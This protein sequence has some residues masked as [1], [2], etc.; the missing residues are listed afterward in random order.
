MTNGTVCLKAIGVSKK[1]G[2]TPALSNIDFSLDNGEIHTVLGAK[3]AGKS[4]LMQVLAGGVSIDAGYV[5]VNG[6]RPRSH[7]PSFARSNGMQSL[8]ESQYLMQDLTVAENIF[9]G[10]YVANRAGFLNYK[11]LK[12][13]AEEIFDLLNVPINPDTLPI[14]LTEFERQVVQMARVYANKAKIVLADNIASLFSNGQKQQIL[15]IMKEMAQ[16]GIGV[17]YFTHMVEDALKISSRITV[18][19]DGERIC[20]KQRKAFDAKNLIHE[21]VGFDETT[22]KC[23]DIAKD[24]ED[25][26]IFYSLSKAAEANENLVD[27]LKNATDYINGHLEESITPQMVADAV[28]LSSGY[29]MMLF[30]N[31]MNTSIMEY[32]YRRRIEKSKSMLTDKS[33]KISQIAADVGIPNSQYFSVLFK[34]YTQMTPKEYRKT[35]TS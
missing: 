25:K 28:H 10:E 13:Q 21:M 23:L 1:F 31:H 5:E 9:M 26:T 34:K 20:V 17:V 35:S 30:K 32:T 11:K 7:N 16:S 24:E 27:Y 19:R 3:G 15:E 4:T 14:N 29:L 2:N 18:I 6:K 22:Q 8:Y 12:N 33:K